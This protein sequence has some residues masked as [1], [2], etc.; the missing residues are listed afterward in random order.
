MQ[1]LDPELLERAARWCAEAGRHVG[2][3]EVR[4]ALAPLGW[5]ELLAVRALLA[6]PPP[7]RPLG[8]HALADLARGAPP[9]V[10]AER[11]REGRYASEADAGTEPEPEPA[12][13]PAARRR[14]GR[15]RGPGVVIH[16]ARD[17]ATPR[18]PSPAPLPALDD[19]RRPEGRAV[20][21]RLVR[22]H[23]ARRAP[24][25]AA[26]AAGWA[27]PGG[28]GPG[29]A[30]LSALLD[31]HGLARAFERRERDELL[32][33]LRAAGGV[34]AAAAAGL[35]LDEDGLSRALARLGAAEQAERIRE[36]R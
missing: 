14:G 24:I 22:T 36:D 16:R 26:L 35:G 29:D 21:E 20:L 2:P 12:E 11:E 30:E 33:A 25:L 5:D 10:A 34:R 13:P 6:D 7:V 23:G 28:A 31:H 4:R 18:P 17:R 15:R 27:S 9:D 3:A 8:P 19:L 32:H 1:D